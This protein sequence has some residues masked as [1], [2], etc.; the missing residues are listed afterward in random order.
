MERNNTKIAVQK[1]IEN[2]ATILNN[3]AVDKLYTCYSEDAIFTP[4]GHQKLHYS[5]I[6]N[7][8]SGKSLK[9]SQFEISYKFEELD[10]DK[11]YAFVNAVGIT[12]TRSENTTTS[13]E[14]SDFFVLKL[15]GTEW[16]IYRHTFNNVK[17]IKN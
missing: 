10:I 9:N 15:V 4:D 8:K 5:D 13:K 11:G 6:T 16:K 17:G 7:L 12:K 1:V 14:S 2:H 3:A